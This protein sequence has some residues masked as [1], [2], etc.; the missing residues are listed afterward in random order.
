MENAL[1]TA[2]TG[3]GFTYVEEYIGASTN[4]ARIYKSPA[5]SNF[6]GQDWYLIVHRPTDN[7]TFVSFR[8]SELYNVGTHK[9]TNYAPTQSI[10]TPTAQFAVNDATGLVPESGSLFQ[11]Q[12]YISASGFQYWMS[13]IADRVVIGTRVGA[14]DYAGY[15]GLYDDLQSATIS[16]FPLLVGN[17]SASGSSGGAA[18]RE[19]ATTTSTSNAF[20]ILSL[21]SSYY[22]LSSGGSYMTTAESYTGKFW[23]G[24]FQIGSNR[25][26]NYARGFIRDV[27][28]GPSGGVNGD[29]LNATINGTAKT[30][31]QVREATSRSFVDT[32]L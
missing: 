1:H 32:A 9:A 25:G 17:L 27:W 19:P 23:L 3:G 8:I 14:S 16:P 5:G 12:L 10:Y 28:F 4:V 21:C 18:T 2:L 30:L 20:S 31:V 6:F 15:A 24:R 7:N 29:T 22:V 26:N 11:Y 13:V